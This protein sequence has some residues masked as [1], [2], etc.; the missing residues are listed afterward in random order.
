MPYANNAGVR[1][2]YQVDGNPD[3]PPLVLQHGFLCCVED[4]YTLGYAAT[5][6]AT[7]RLILTDARG[8]GASDKPHEPAAYRMAAMADDVV[9]VL[10]DLGLARAH[11]FGYSMGGKIGFV[12]AARAPER[13][14]SFVL[15]GSSAADRD[16]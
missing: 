3:G 14:R 2:H 11:F 13:C 6:G 5:L 7:Y 8:H 16:P 12:L 15:G 1:I 9:A 4:W 10:D